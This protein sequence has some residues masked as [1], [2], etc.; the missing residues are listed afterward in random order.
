MKKLLLCALA[1]G[2]SGQVWARTI[3]VE[4]ATSRGIFM[5]GKSMNTWCGPL[6]V[7]ISARSKM[8]ITTSQDCKF[9][10][11]L[12]DDLKIGEINV[13]QKSYYKVTEKN[14]KFYLE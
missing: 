7:E 12:R 3:T 8:D 6:V 9:G 13:Q 1:L 14:G 2:I 10:V 4:N 11:F 5:H